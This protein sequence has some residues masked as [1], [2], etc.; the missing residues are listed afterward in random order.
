MIYFFIILRWFLNVSGVNQ[1][2]SYYS[3]HSS[4]SF[5]HWPTPTINMRWSCRTFSRRCNQRVPSN[6]P[7]YLCTEPCDRLLYH[8]VLRRCATLKTDARRSCWI[9][10]FRLGAALERFLKHATRKIQHYRNPS[11]NNNLNFMTSHYPRIH[12]PTTGQFWSLINPIFLITTS[13][14]SST[15]FYMLYSW[16]DNDQ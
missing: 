9:S 6:F 7:V 11:N 15:T 4:Y 8:T 13:N 10:I 14:W 2:L 16:F 1:S 3:N 12:L 5:T